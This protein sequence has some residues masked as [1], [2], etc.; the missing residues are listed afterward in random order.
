[1]NPGLVIDNIKTA[2][3]LVAGKL[4]PQVLVAELSAFFGGLVLL[5]ACVGLYGSMAD[6]LA[7]RTREIGV[8]MD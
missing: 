8:R 1:M 4:T 5:L 6:N 7:A 2:D 3:E